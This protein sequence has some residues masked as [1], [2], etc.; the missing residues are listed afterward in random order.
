M[1]TDTIVIERG[2][3]TFEHEFD[4]ANALPPKQISDQD[5]F[6][7]RV[8]DSLLA[9]YTKRTNKAGGSDDEILLS[10]GADTVT[11]ILTQDERNSI[12]DAGFTYKLSYYNPVFEEW[13]VLAHGDVTNTGT[14]PAEEDPGISQL[15]AVNG[16]NK[17][18]LAVSFN[19]HVLDDYVYADTTE[20]AIIGTLPNADAFGNVKRYIFKNKGTGVT[21][22]TLTINDHLGNPVIILAAE[23]SV[24]VATNGTA[25]EVLFTGVGEIT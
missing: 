9:R 21:P 3:G 17:R 4:F 11:I 8:E 18:T 15:S 25:W 5:Q 22:G 24:K 13:E 12:P 1:I 10:E 7:L 6:I 19:V 2:E 14:A 20:G 16:D 23:E